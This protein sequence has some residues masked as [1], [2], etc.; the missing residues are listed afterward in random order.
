MDRVFRGIDYLC[1]DMVCRQDVDPTSAS[2][3]MPGDAASIKLVD[4]L[5]LYSGQSILS[6]VLQHARPGNLE[7]WDQGLLEDPTT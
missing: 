6:T 3:D 2:I 4:T 1:I 5:G 7:K